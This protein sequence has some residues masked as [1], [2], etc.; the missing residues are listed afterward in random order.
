[1]RATPF[2]RAA[3]DAWWGP[4]VAAAEPPCAAPP[5]WAAFCEGVLAGLPEVPEPV[6]AGPLPGTSGFRSVLRPFAERAGALL[7]TDLPGARAELAAL[8]AA[9]VDRLTAELARRA[10]RTLVLELHAA[11]AAGRLSGG[12][13]AARFRSFLRLVGGRAG[14]AALLAEY[15]VLARL[16]ARTCLD[17]AAALGELLERFAADRE[18]IVA[19]LLGGADPG[20]LVAV[21]RTS[22]DG[23]R[24]GR[25]VAV[26]RFAGGAR[27]V[28]KPRPMEAHAHLG[29]LVAWFGARPGA[30]RLRTPA[31]LARSG[32]GWVEFVAAGPCADEAAVD[33]FYRRQGALLA[34]L[35]VLDATD[36]HLENLI[37]AGDQPVPVDVETLFHPPALSR[38]PSGPVDPAAL[39]LAGSVHRTGLLPTLL[40]G[41]DSARDVSGLGGDAGGA[42]P[43]EVVDWAEAGTDRM[44]L[45]RRAHAAAGAANR[46]VLHGRLPD[47]AAYQEALLAGFRA[48]WRVLLAGREELLGEDGL[49]AR[50]FRADEVRV[51]ARATQ[52]YWTL[53]EESTHPDALRG[54]E[55]REGLLELLGA[56]GFGDPGLGWLLAEE[57][58]EL[59]DGD[60]PLFTARPGSADLWSGRGRRFP[61]ALGRTGLDRVAE[62]LAALGPRDLERQEWIVRAALAGRS[63]APAH[64][65]S[66]P[67]PAGGDLGPVDPERLL[68]AARTLGDRLVGEAHRGPDR[69]N[70]LG[71]D[72]LGERYWR[73]APAG[74]DLA[75]GYPGPALFLAQLAS[76]TGEARYAETARLA[77]RP[78]PEL[79]ERLAGLRPADGVGAVG[80]GAFCGLG[81]VAYALASVAVLLDDAGLRALLEPAVELTV[82]AAGAEESTALRD[83]TAGALAALLAV[84]RATGS[85]G[86]LRGARTCAALLLE[87]PLPAQGSFAGGAAG[88]GWALLAFAATPAPGG[89]PY[90]EA[91]LAALRRAVAA[92]PAGDSWCEG[93][94]GVALAVADS[95]AAMADPGLA[96][97]AREAARA[98]AAGAPLA[99]L[100]PC[101]GEAG[102]RELLGSAAAPAGRADGPRPRGPLAAA[103]PGPDG[104]AGRCGTPGGLAVPGLLTGRAGIGL[105]LLR[106]GFPGRTDSVLLMRSPGG[107]RTSTGTP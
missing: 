34:L 102:V 27:V 92:G 86:A 107:A 39:A 24:G 51:V 15:P 106:L 53:L 58:A 38:R 29:A 2:E 77:L 59:R 54:A 20:R 99:D 56:P 94:T 74:A 42:T 87:R 70:W 26:L 95:P 104:G 100:S 35:Y 19:G 93:R 10:A 63:A 40:L 78:V 88:V 57:A 3:A 96:R 32:Y 62:R 68:A 76:L 64:T 44:H 49:L 7:P 47:P 1:M 83:G 101:H 31:V 16:L 33:R 97:F 82:A 52:V 79:L 61:G 71:L 22:G 48:G 85:A 103:L 45:V 98:A 91:G 80:S 72:L 21:E 37:A 43:V 81:G 8:R 17:A 11:G 84:H 75:C 41:E 65:V 105:G 25:S 69:V 23:H 90:R 55:E 13:P 46:P 6:A 9:F 60:I 73:L 5:D 18:G 50:L 28:Y 12:D 66:G 4:G 14:S 89:A 30:P 67:A 36:L